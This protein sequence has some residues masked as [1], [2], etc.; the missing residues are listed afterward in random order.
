[1]VS[2][3]TPKGSHHDG[4][5]NNMNF[6]KKSQFLEISPSTKPLNG[7][8]N[9][10]KQ[11]M[12]VA[13]SQWSELTDKTNININ[14]MGSNSRSDLKLNGQ[15]STQHSILSESSTF[16]QDL[17]SRD[18]ANY[19]GSPLPPSNNNLIKH[20]NNHKPISIPMKSLPPNKPIP[21]MPNRS[22][23]NN[24]YYMN[25]KALPP[26]NMMS[27]SLNAPILSTPRMVSAASSSSS[28][29]TDFVPIQAVVGSVTHTD[30][31]FLQSSITN[32]NNNNNHH[33][34]K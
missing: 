25:N 24:N 15:H 22:L 33:N 30:V 11:T 10:Q 7:T 18:I 26:T 4:N 14:G 6:R 32:A 31:K 5:M 34:N 28:R 12:S 16:T 13:S 19:T 21:S 1:V 23:P 2:K 17:N 27:K 29:S 8:R 9:R 3:Q 20:N